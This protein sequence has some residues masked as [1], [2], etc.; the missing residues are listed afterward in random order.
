MLYK[1]TVLLTGVTFL[2]LTG[3]T[4]RLEQLY[5]MAAL[6]A[7]LAL[8]SYVVC[9]LS[10]RGID[11]RR[12]PA[13][14][15]YED[16]Q[17]ELRMTLTNTSRL[18]KLF[19]A[20]EDVL[21]R[22]LEP[23]GGAA[24]D[25]GRNPTHRPPAEVRFVVPMLLPG[26]SVELRYR[27]RGEKRG[28]FLLG[29]IA[30]SA[31]DA[32]GAFVVSRPVQA[33]QEII[34]YPSPARVSPEAVA[35]VRSFGEADTEQLSAAGAGLE[36]YGIRDYR[37]GDALRRIH[38]PSTAR[39]GDF[40]VVE[41]EESFGADMVIALDLRAG[42]E[43]G[44]GKDTTLE[45]AI[46]AAA[47]LAAHAVDNG[48]SAT[49]IGHDARARHLASAPRP[50]E[51]PTVLE[52]LARMQADGDTPLAAAI[53]RV[54]DLVTGAAGI[55]LTSALDETVAAAAESWLRR[56]AQV[57]VILFDAASWGAD[58]A[59]DVYAF[60]NRLRAAGARVEVIRR[61]DDLQYMLGR[62][63]SDAV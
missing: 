8:G 54:S 13:R 53:A 24:P 11:V 57:V 26:R 22:W 14:K 58:G 37:P 60:G 4:L 19:L 21:P 25:P 1:Q 56:R 46:R 10:V 5:F 39:L 40:A 50:E 35:G 2:G 43:Y 52:V 45:A 38:W 23:V 63:A 62:A 32:L 12:G 16:Q 61:G 51:L 6:L 41:F 47:S 9:A 18:P 48:A 3:Y 27:V 28:A 15:I 49:V 59:G 44:T 55:L 20:I 29:P 31:T 30:V 7:F 42:T 33:P 17:S 34:V 36:F